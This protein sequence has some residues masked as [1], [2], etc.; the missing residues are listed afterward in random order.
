MGTT[1]TT[2][3]PEVTVLFSD[4]NFL[5]YIHGHAIVSAHAYTTLYRYILLQRKFE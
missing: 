3:Y 4:D 2:S 1:A 5:L